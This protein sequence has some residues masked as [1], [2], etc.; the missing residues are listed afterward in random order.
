MGQYEKIKDEINVGSCAASAA[1]A[2]KP[3]SEGGDEAGPLHKPNAVAAFK[4]IIVK[5]EVSQKTV[6]KHD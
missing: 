6:S 2:V 4:Y 1:C 3:A 5:Y